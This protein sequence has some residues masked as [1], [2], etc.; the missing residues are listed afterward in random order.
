MAEVEGIWLP[1][2]DLVQ[3]PVLTKEKLYCVVRRKKVT[4]E[5]PRW[6]GL[7]RAPTGSVVC[8]IGPNSASG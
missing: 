1:K 5:S 8:R 6:W 7:V 2:L 3:L 4:A